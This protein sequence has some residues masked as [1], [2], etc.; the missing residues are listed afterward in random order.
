MSLKSNGLFSS[1]GIQRILEVKDSQGIEILF[2]FVYSISW[3]WED[4][5]LQNLAVHTVSCT[6]Q[7]L[8][9]VGVFKVILLNVFCT[10]EVL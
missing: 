1:D 7:F 4:V 5:S 8:T 9:N 2:L 6:F 10:N 3:D